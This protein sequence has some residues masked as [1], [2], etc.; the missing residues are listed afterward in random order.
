MGRHRT[1]MEITGGRRKEK[2][3]DLERSLSRLRH[4]ASISRRSS[5]KST[6]AKEEPTASTSGG[7][8]SFKLLRRGRSMRTV[9]STQASSP[10]DTEPPPRSFRA[11]IPTT[12]G[13]NNYAK[14]RVGAARASAEVLRYHHPVSAQV[15]S[16]GPLT[17]DRRVSSWG[18]HPLEL[19]NTSFTDDDDII[20]DGTLQFGRPSMDSEDEPE[21]NRPRP[22]L[23]DFPL[24]A[25]RP[26]PLQS[27]VDE[28]YGVITSNGSVGPEDSD[29][30]DDESGINI[31]FGR[32][33]RS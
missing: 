16:S 32:Q 6:K 29:S 5:Q 14:S 4:S 19:R 33:P 1:V 26:T 30:D 27:T 23:Y 7:F 31:T 2:G 8:I 28:D 3:K 21:D 17:S 10:E 20:G 18:D 12:T 13:P 24:P 15:S 25:M 22:R 11:G 9:S